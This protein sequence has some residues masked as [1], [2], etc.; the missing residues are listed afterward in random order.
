MGNENNIPS[1]N[2][3]QFPSDKKY[4]NR[5]TSLRNPLDYINF[6]SRAEE[7][8]LLTNLNKSTTISFN[9]LNILTIKKIN[10][11]LIEN[12]LKYIQITDDFIDKKVNGNM[13]FPYKREEN[14]YI[15]LINNIFQNTNNENNKLNNN[16]NSPNIRIISNNNSNGKIQK[17]KKIVLNNIKITSKNNNR[18]IIQN[19]NNRANNS[20]LNNCKDNYIIRRSESPSDSK[21]K[22][23]AQLNVFSFN[24]TIGG[25]NSPLNSNRNNSDNMNKNNENIKYPL[26]VKAFKIGKQEDFI[27]QRNNILYDSKYSRADSPTSAQTIANN[28]LTNDNTIGGNSIPSDISSKLNNS[29]FVVEDE[30]KNIN[31]YI[32][33]SSPRNY[34]NNKNIDIQNNFSPKNQSPSNN[35]R[36][37][38]KLLIN[39]NYIKK[40]SQNNIDISNKKKKK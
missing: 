26:K 19:Q 31:N 7:N 21:K 22:N 4:K 36:N 25:N 30:K 28:G 15:Q 12:Q 5:I 34:I 3:N 1:Q 40:S 14:R 8:I 16:I 38:P 33:K 35:N 17:N 29:N 24:T 10:N 20:F 37:K 39:D 27:L 32:E 11:N 23:N 2:R 18:I 9:N 13:N 6:V